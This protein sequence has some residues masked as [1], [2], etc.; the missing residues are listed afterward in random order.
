M[1]Q[2]MGRRGIRL[3]LLVVFGLHLGG[4]TTAKAQPIRLDGGCPLSLDP[5]V[6][7]ACDFLNNASLRFTH[8][9]SGTSINV[10]MNNQGNV[11]FSGR[12][13]IITGAGLN[14]TQGSREF[15]IQ[16]VLVTDNAEEGV[17]ID[18]KTRACIQSTDTNIAPSQVF[19]SG[20]VSST[21]SSRLIFQSMTKLQAH[22]CP[23][24]SC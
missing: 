20:V 23:D 19:T 7:G 16:D 11:T 12:V 21:T 6:G 9:A 13:A 3:P 8:T 4:W 1:S 15:K 17:Q 5:D 24:G 10:S 22:F 14:E 18:C 2:G